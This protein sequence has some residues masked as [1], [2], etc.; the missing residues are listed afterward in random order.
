MSEMVILPSSDGSDLAELADLACVTVET[1]MTPLETMA[2]L[3]TDLTEASP[4]AMVSPLPPPSIPEE[5][6][7]GPR[8]SQIVPL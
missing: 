7:E 8:E 5:I 6:T 3:E 2:A 4:H 1:E